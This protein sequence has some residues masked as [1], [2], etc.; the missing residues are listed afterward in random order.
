MVLWS[1]VIFVLFGSIR[2]KGEAA[3][4]LISIRPS[5]RWLL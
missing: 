1:F 5:N 2:S 3:V 4:N